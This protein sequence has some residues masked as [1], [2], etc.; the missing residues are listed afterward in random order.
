MGR[1]A[2][3][4]VSQ[5]DVNY[6]DSALSRGAA[7]KL[8]GGD[9]LPWVKIGQGEADNFAALT[10]MDWQIH[11]YGHATLELRT[12]ADGRKIPLHVF[13][14]GPGMRRAGLRRDALYL[15][16]PDGYIGLADS[17]GSATAIGTY[18]SEKS[19]RTIN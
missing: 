6:R 11:V 10:S 7:G 12:L 16:R 9:R 15:I 17:A 1:F 14:W 5:I 4:T 18:L 19:L 3:R 8:H 13:P 2:F